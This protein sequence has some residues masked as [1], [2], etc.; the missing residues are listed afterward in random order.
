MK[1]EGT[2]EVKMSPASNPEDRQE[3]ISLDRM[4]LDKTYNGELSGT[5]QGEMLTA[6]TPTKGSAGYVAI[7]QVRGRLMDK[8]GSFVLQHYG[9]MGGGEETLVLEIVPDS[10][11]GDLVG[12]KGR[13]SIQIQDGV[14]HYTLEYDLP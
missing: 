10:G 1:V 9:L 3:G 7:E 11:S 4:L 12:I 13:M 5:G 14:H 6:I 8:E 2:F